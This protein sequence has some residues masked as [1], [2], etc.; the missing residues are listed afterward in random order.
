MQKFLGFA[1]YFQPF[2]KDYATLAARLYQM[3]T[4]DFDWNPKEWKEDFENIFNEFKAALQNSQKLFYP[5][6]TKKWILRTDASLLG[7]GGVLLQEM[8]VE[9]RKELMPLFFVSKKFSPAAM[10]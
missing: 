4:K 2:V 7:I 9:G 8:E 10:K 5:D 1:I 6:Y 3:T